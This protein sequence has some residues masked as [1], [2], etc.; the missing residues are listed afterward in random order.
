MKILLIW[1]A[2][3]TVLLNV[4]AQ[5]PVFRYPF[6]TAPKTLPDMLVMVH[7]TGT[8]TAF[9]LKNGK[10]IEYLLTGSDF[11]I[12]SGF[13]HSQTPDKT[14]YTTTAIPAG[15]VFNGQKLYNFL[16]DEGG[17]GGRT[18]TGKDVLLMDVVDFSKKQSELSV[19]HTFETGEKVVN[20]FTYRNTI[21]IISVPASGDAV[22]VC[23]ID[24]VLNK[25][26]RTYP[27]SVSS[28]VSG[29]QTLDNL[30]KKAAV[31]YPD[32]ENDFEAATAA[33]KINPQPGK[34]IITSDEKDRGTVL[35]IIDLYNNKLE[36]KS[37]DMDELCMNGEKNSSVNSAVVGNQL[38][39]SCACKQ[40]INLAVYDYTTGKLIKK[41]ESA[42]EK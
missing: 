40:K 24:S 20:A 35:S 36:Q 19:K 15:F 10:K 12:T 16:F 25:T 21:Y 37:L 38:F 5:K 17:R 2:C 22:S 26:V 28:L 9:L 23:Y 1:A 18:T 14:I 11:K 42:K 13:V 31:R 39:V 7:P 32:R 3:V 6:E 8:Q 4:Q 33:I 30:L 29:Y 41:H 34:I 27:L